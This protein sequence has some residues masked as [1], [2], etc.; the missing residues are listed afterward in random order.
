M[1]AQL[2]S[3][4]SSTFPDLA[5]SL[6]N[7]KLAPP[8][9]TQLKVIRQLIAA[10]Y[11]DQVAVRADLISNESV[12]SSST[13]HADER[14]N[15]ML[16]RLRTKGGGD[17][18]QSTRGVPY[19]AMGVPGYAFIHPTSCF[20]HATPPT[21]VVFS[22]VQQ[23]NSKFAGDDDQRTVWLKTLTKI[24]PV[25]LSTL[26]RALCS[27]G[28]PTPVDGVEGLKASVA[29]VKAGQMAG[30]TVREVVVTP[31]YAVG[32]EEDGMAGGLGW[33]LPAMRAKQRFVDG[34]WVLSLA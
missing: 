24:N 34:R 4:I 17:R 22:E 6:S 25:W 14:T 8:N 12:V 27:F 10:A 5:K 15:Q 9:E 28:K 23:S 31:T 13:V 11:I 26:G 19:K 29:A 3:L 18:M 2:C 30:G 21:W 20:Y 33:T 7:P 1:R 32:S 16:F